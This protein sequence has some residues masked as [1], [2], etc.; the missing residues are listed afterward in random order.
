MMKI[1]IV[2][3]ACGPGLGSEPGNT[4][5][6]AWQLSRTH[7]VWVIAHPEYKDRVDRF[8]AHQPNQR[9]HVHLDYA[10]KPI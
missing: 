2:G 10:P 5:N 8:L 1:L 9:L 4:W 7:E 6:W 3:H